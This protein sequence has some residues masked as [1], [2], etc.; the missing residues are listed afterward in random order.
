MNFAIERTT[1][2]RMNDE[3]RGIALADLEER[4]LKLIRPRHN[5]LEGFEPEHAGRI[6]DPRGNLSSRGVAGEDGNPLKV[7]NRIREQLKSLRE[8]VDQ[9]KAQAGYVSA[10]ST[11]A[12]H[13]S[14]RNRVRRTAQDDGNRIRRLDDS[15]LNDTRSG[16]DGI[17][18][19]LNHL[20]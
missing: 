8:Q 15:L 10:G 3:T 16:N 1:S 4:L 9:L 13:E 7:R 5:E 20:P 14:L 17:R 12:L 11:Q 6:V 18:N 2:V 19:R